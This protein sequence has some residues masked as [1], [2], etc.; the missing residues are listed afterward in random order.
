MRPVAVVLTLVA[1]CLATAVSAAPVR[2][3][4]MYPIQIVDT[5][6][7]NATGGTTTTSSVIVPLAGGGSVSLN[8]FMQK[9]VPASLAANGALPAASGAAPAVLPVKLPGVKGYVP[10]KKHPVWVKVTA[11]YDDGVKIRETRG[12]KFR[13]TIAEPG[14]W[15][16]SSYFVTNYSAWARVNKLHTT[17]VAPKPVNI[18]KGYNWVDP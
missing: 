4:G 13:G 7:V 11:C 18:V 17:K 16:I 14:D 15:Q 10:A 2:L 9:V 12:E 5:V 8:T 1:V 6:K 3:V